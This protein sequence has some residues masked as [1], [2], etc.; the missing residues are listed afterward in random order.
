MRPPTEEHP[1]T[2]GCE[3]TEEEHPNA[4]GCEVTEEDRGK[5]TK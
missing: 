4:F 2:F 5:V 3:V 1:N